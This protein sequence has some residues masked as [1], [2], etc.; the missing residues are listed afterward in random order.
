MSLYCPFYSRDPEIFNDEIIFFHDFGGTMFSAQLSVL[1]ADADVS[2]PPQS[3]LG[4]D[5]PTITN[6]WM[7]TSVQTRFDP[8][9]K[10]PVLFIWFLAEVE[11]LPR[12]M[13][14]IKIGEPYVDS[15]DGGIRPRPTGPPIIYTAPF[16]HDLFSDD[17]DYS[18]NE[19]G[20]I[21]RSNL[22]AQRRVGA[23]PTESYDPPHANCTRG[24]SAP[25]SHIVRM[26]RRGVWDGVTTVLTSLDKSGRLVHKPLHISTPRESQRGRRGA[27]PAS[28]EE[29]FAQW[30]SLKDTILWNELS[31][32]L[33]VENSSWRTN[34]LSFTIYQF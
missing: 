20:K 31:G 12:K 18:H 30:S 24:N 16:T 10:Q 23:T 29:Q 34:T 27:K 5:F 11:G 15:R 26:G 21:A 9:S 3:W 7:L 33:A 25:L 32:R 17:T 8:V 2:P 6:V 19:F 14:L 13:H 1:D 22:K 4:L 28:A